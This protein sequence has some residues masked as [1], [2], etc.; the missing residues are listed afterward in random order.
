M[1][2]ICQTRTITRHY[3]NITLIGGAN[4]TRTKAKQNRN[5]IG[6][7]VDKIKCKEIEF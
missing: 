4:Y 7:W 5:K 6:I 3:P 2:S 1:A